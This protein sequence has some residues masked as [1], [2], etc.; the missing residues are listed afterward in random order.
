[1]E[2]SEL[3]K[4]LLDKR[5]ISDTESFLNPNYEDHCHDP[6][7]LPDMKKALQR[8]FTALERNEHIAI[9]TDFDCDGVAGAAVFSDFLEKIGYR[10]AEVYMPHR[11]NEGYGFH[12][13]AIRELQARGTR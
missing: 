5:G 4:T 13:Q 10:E 8:F 12:E 6:L 7:L 9:Y 11:D 2:I 1:M 3:L